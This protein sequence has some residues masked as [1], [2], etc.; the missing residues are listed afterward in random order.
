LLWLLQF[1]A[2][3][4]TTGVL[5][6]YY[7]A[8]WKDLYYF[9]VTYT[10]LFAV[11]VLLYL[12]V[13]GQVGTSFGLQNLF[14]SEQPL[15]R[16]F[17]SFSATLLLGLI[18]TLA[19][20]IDPQPLHSALK[21]NEFLRDPPLQGQAALKAGSTFRERAKVASEHLKRGP[22][23]PH[24]RRLEPFL[25]AARL[26][27]LTLLAVPAFLPDIF[28]YLPRPYLLTDSYSS[29]ENYPSLSPVVSNA[30]VGYLYGLVEWV[31]GI[32]FGVFTFKLFMRLSVV[33]HDLISGPLKDW[34]GSMGKRVTSISPRVWTVI[35]IIL[36]TLPVLAT[37]VDLMAWQPALIFSVL[38]YLFFFRQE[39]ARRLVS[40]FKRINKVVLGWPDFQ[41][42]RRYTPV[43][44][45]GCKPAGDREC[46]VLGCPAVLPPE[47]NDL[48]GC[49]ERDDRQT[50]IRNVMLWFIIFYTLSSLYF[51]DYY[52]PSMAICLVLAVLAAFTTSIAY[53]QPR[54]KYL[55]L[56]GFFAY[57]VLLNNQVYKDRFEGL[58]DYYP[59]ALH[60]GSERLVKLREKTEFI[61]YPSR[62]AGDPDA[63]RTSPTV[64]LVDNRK[65][66]EAWRT[67]AE[68]EWKR[69]RRS[70]AKKPKLVVV[71]V[72][73]GA[74]R[75]AYW[76]A[77][78]LDRLSS[79][80][81]PTFNR[82]VR[83]ITGTSGG[84]LGTAH[85]VERLYR[86]T[87]GSSTGKGSWVDEVR[88]DSLVRLA[89][90][91]ALCDLP[92]SFLPRLVEHR[93]HDGSVKEYDRGTKLEDDWCY[94]GDRA[95]QEYAFLERNGDIPS[96]IF[97]PMILEDGRLLLIS[98]L[99]LREVAHPQKTIS[100]IHVPL[101][102]EYAWN[103]ELCCNETELRLMPMSVGSK[104]A[105]NVD[106]TRVLPY[107]L[108]GLEFY[109]LFPLATR[110]RV[111]T[112][113]RMNATFPYI[114]PAVSLPT[115]PPRHIVDAGYYDNYG[116]QVS[117]SWLQM[118]REWLIEN[119]SGVL[120]IQ[121]RDGLSELDRFETDDHS[122]TN[123]ERI[124]RGFEFLLNPVKGAFRARSST[125]MFRN[126]L[127][128]AHLSDWFTLATGRSDFFSTLVF[129]NPAA[130]ASL[131]IAKDSTKMPGANLIE[132]LRHP[133][134][135]DATKLKG[136]INYKLEEGQ[137]MTKEARRQL[138]LSHR[139]IENISMNWYLTYSELEAMQRTF[140]QQNDRAAQDTEVASQERSSQ[141]KK[142]QEFVR[143]LRD[144]PRDYALRALVQLQN[145]HGL[146]ALKDHW[147]WLDHGSE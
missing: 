124:A 84:M 90:Y 104:I 45:E 78:V 125:S 136:D 134:T 69:D 29:L 58:D 14:W 25:R 110:F 89:P 128:V 92:R 12:I 11:M 98:N 10:G 145:Y 38:L 20:H 108:S 32:V 4:L 52:S 141:I 94:L 62:T 113:V 115:D 99:D 81:G 2:L 68:Q 75:S 71:S 72:S 126:D 51:Y 48:D 26:P 49:L 17:S 56:L 97:S 127:E 138:G 40:V 15:A 77:V 144:E 143:I 64:S 50:S 103:S 63:N 5:S 61:Y 28:T 34:I 140:P 88:V 37:V 116:I 105:Q 79:T 41:Q 100:R 112:A 80:L 27:F 122:T 111:A 16:F 8:F 93:R 121:I 59:R 39:I 86:G 137:R 139:Y 131:P 106:G 118:N 31:G 107:S 47:E 117:T 74:S 70:R 30:F 85:Y 6:V 120:L 57:L 23:T 123:W 76:C 60:P 43:R 95:L 119:T 66:L 22:D 142:L 19:C 67:R 7:R 33:T 132:V 102:S 9:A 18:G 91:I 44:T 21:I 42:S 54:K 130:V 96:L 36:A 73:G 146:L 83:I 35:E 3:L 24:M 46:P 129:E 1:V 55:L 101:G 65:S 82:S 135:L 53:F 114:S 133:T 13:Y 109:K 87:M 147:W